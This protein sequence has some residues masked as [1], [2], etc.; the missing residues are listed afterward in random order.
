MTKKYS[1]MRGIGLI[2]VLVALF[3]LAIGVLG[4]AAMQMNALKFNQNAAVRSQ[5]TFLAYEIADAMRANRT[6][7]L[8]G[9]YDLALDDDP[10]TGAVVGDDLERWRAALSERLPA[11]SGGVARNGNVFT[12][13][14][15][16]DESRL[17]AADD[18]ATEDDDES[19]GR[20]VFV[21]EL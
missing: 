6:V 20:F 15:E 16:W 17:G 14:I 11:G 3:I 9:G 8:A 5:A 19:K 1:V 18:S 4:A 13:T 21:T 7:A 2:E 10:P 12:I